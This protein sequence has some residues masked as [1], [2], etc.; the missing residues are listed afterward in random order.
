MYYEGR[1][2]GLWFIN[3][4]VKLLFLKENLTDYVITE[5]LTFI[6]N[7]LSTSYVQLIYACYILKT[8]LII[9]IMMT[10]MMIVLKNSTQKHFHLS[11]IN[12]EN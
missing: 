9:E 1:G 12:S 3:T 6:S 4:F 8:M 2:G 10:I 7:I 5:M 11:D